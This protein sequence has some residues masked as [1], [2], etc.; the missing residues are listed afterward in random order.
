MLKFYSSALMSSSHLKRNR[1]ET[2]ER[3]FWENTCFY[4]RVTLPFPIL[5][6]SVNYWYW[7]LA[8]VV[9]SSWLFM[10]KKRLKQASSI[11]N[12]PVSGTHCQRRCSWKGTVGKT[13]FHEFL[14]FHYQNKY[15]GTSES[16]KLPA[17]FLKVVMFASLFK[18]EGPYY[19][20]EESNYTF[21][22]NFREIVT[23]SICEFLKP[24]N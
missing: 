7:V 20:F 3:G 24:A 21:R 19:L 6:E 9:Y 12:S 22:I 4:K 17:N 8:L 13:Y 10:K 16:W 18:A 2:A 5:Y 14:S 15:L 23:K 1:K 11:R